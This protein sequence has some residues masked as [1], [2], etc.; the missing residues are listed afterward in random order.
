MWMSKRIVATSE[1]EVAEKGKVTLSENQ[2]EAGATVTRRNIDSYAPYGYKSVPPVDEDVIMLESND[3]A[4]VL[5]ALS[6]DEDIES[7]EVKISS[8]GGAY[9]ILKNNGDIVLNGLVIDSR[10]VIQNE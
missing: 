8:L 4:V 3:G 5:G 6:K 2:L 1:K 7:G 10:G 9:I